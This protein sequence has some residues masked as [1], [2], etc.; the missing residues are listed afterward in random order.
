MNVTKK[1]QV[2]L[3]LQQDWFKDLSQID[4]TSMILVTAVHWSVSIEDYEWSN[5][6]INP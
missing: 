3:I 2:N 5:L 4:I 1:C 6:T